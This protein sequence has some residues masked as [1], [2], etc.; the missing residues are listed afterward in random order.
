MAHGTP[1]H[2]HHTQESKQNYVVPW[3]TFALYLYDPAPPISPSPHCLIIWVLEIKP[4]LLDLVT[5]VLTH[6]AILPVP[7]WHVCVCVFNTT[8]FL[9]QRSI[10]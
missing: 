7:G 1:T 8:Y 6:S 2:V 9:Y 3:L 5:I 4:S 10:S